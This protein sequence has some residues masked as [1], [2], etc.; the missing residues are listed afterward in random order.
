[1]QSRL[2]PLQAPPQLVKLAPLP[3]LAVR[4]TVAPLLKLALQVPLPQE[5]PDGVDVTLPLPVPFM[6]TLRV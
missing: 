1:M 3:G 2:V 5:M 4:R 6:V